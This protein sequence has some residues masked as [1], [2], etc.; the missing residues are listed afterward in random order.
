MALEVSFDQV[1]QVGAAICGALTLAVGALATWFYNLFKELKD[2]LDECE[3][4]HTEQA[5]QTAELKGRL[6]EIERL[7]PAVLAD[8]VAK[9]VV[10]AMKS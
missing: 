10:K 2:D 8:T 1:W 7:N 4:K 5:I 9:A 6:D 3:R